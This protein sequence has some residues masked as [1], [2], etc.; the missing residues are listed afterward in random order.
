M[1]PSHI[2]PCGA[3]VRRMHYGCCDK[4][5]FTYTTYIHKTEQRPDVSY[6]VKIVPKPGPRGIKKSGPDGLGLKYRALV[7]R[8]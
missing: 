2:A 5:Y 7:Q 6:D 4:M 3:C 1:R 8:P